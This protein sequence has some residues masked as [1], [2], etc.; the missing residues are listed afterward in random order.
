MDARHSIGYLLNEILENAV[1]FRETGN[2]EVIC[3]L[4]NGRFEAGIAN[5]ISRETTDS[6][7]KH[8]NV[9]LKKDPGELLL[10]R[11]E[12]NALDPE[13]GGSGLGLLTLM[14]DYGAELGWQF[15]DEHVNG[16]VRLNTIAAL[17]LS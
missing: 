4:E 9:M 3:S 2:I 8:L 6:F 17:A 7:Q 11:I 12:A 15:E 1:K 5:V 13:S 10:E 14:N 16:H